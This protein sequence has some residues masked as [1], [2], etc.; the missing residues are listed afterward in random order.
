M[1]GDNL[2]ALI[3]LTLIQ[4]SEHTLC[5]GWLHPLINVRTS[6]PHSLTH[7]QP[8]TSSHTHSH[9]HTHTQTQSALLIEMPFLISPS[10]GNK[11]RK[12]PSLSLSLSNK[13]SYFLVFSFSFTHTH[14]HTHSHYDGVG[15]ST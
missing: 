8:D 14:S 3:P 6:T 2:K 10:V 5:P 1:C 9:I 11:L 15:L 13:V 7:T 4:I 12:K